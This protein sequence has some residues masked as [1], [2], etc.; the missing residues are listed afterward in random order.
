MG[1]TEVARRRSLADTAAAGG[2]SVRQ[3]EQA[4]RSEGGVPRGT[5]RT[6]GPG[7]PTPAPGCAMCPGEHPPPTGPPARAAERTNRLRPPCPPGTGGA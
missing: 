2:W 6:R 4:V 5:S 7:S 1:I 3:L